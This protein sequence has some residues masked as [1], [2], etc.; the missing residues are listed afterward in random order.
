MSFTAPGYPHLTYSQ[1]EQ[2]WIQAGGSKA[3][4]P[5]MAAIALAESGGYAGATNPTDNG[6]TQTS[7]GLWQI[8]NGT[9]SSPAPAGTDPYNP[10]ENARL[11]V[12][13]YNSQGLGAW[14]TYTSGAYRQYYQSN[15]PPT[16]LPQGGSG[17]SPGS[18]GQPPSAILTSFNPISGTESVVGDVGK[19]VTG[20]FGI[21]KHGIS[22]TVDALGAIARALGTMAELSA[23]ML[24][25][26]NPINELRIL[27]AVLGL[28]VLG[29]AIYLVATS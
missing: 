8:S 7:W 14:G 29:I 10:L 4:A 22:S 19:L 15:V 5:L 12:Q 25:L 3:L 27:S 1:L 21:F 24:W 18:A 13:K 23:A 16:S 17:T 20:G 9:H 6:G 11:A 2:V 28:V 26:F